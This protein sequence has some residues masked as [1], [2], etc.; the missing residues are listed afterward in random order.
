MMRIRTMTPLALVL[1]LAM[2]ACEQRAGETGEME[3]T[4]DSVSAVSAEAQLD[5]LRIAYENAWNAGDMAAIPGMMTSDYEELGPEGRLNYDQAIAM[6]S[7]SANMPPP[8]ATLS[9]NME[10][11]EVAESGDVAYSS[12]TSTVTV[13]GAEG[14]EGM[15]ETMRWVAGFKRVDGAWKIDKLAFA[16]DVEAPA[17]PSEGAADTTA[18]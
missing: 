6:M 16:P 7:D 4:A 14:G 9:I 10:S 5:S 3:G 13:P 12:G 15:S 2:V 1:A 8:G 11:T 17:T 18:M